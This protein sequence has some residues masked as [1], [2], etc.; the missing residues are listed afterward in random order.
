MKLF[1]FKSFSSG[2]SIIEVLIATLVVGVVMTAVAASLTASIRNTAE[3]K[4][5]A[6]A[7]D[8]AQ[9]AMEVFRSQRGL[10]GWATFQDVLASTDQFCLNDLPVTSDEFKAAVISRSTCSGGT[11]ETGEQFR[12]MAYV[13]I[14]DS[15]TTR[16]IIEVKWFDA[17]RE[18]KVE[19]VQEFKDL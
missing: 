2:Q 13:T 19:L 8:S 7:Q 12:R 11:R 6:Q 9:E 16:V 4:L 17:D 15:S 10:L 1:N 14:V 5:R 18:R 3:S